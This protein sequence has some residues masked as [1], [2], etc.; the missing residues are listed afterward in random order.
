M[1]VGKK[2]LDYDSKLWNLPKMLKRNQTDLDR[3]EEMMRDDSP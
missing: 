1:V 3:L 2:C